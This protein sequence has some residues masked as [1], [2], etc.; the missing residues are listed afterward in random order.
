[1]GGVHECL[2]RVGV[3]GRGI[4]VSFE[5]G[6]LICDRFAVVVRSRAHCNVMFGSGNVVLA[7]QREEF[8]PLG[9]CF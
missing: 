6:K 2:V 9:E 5:H 4:G 3:G 8:L 7:Q 1:M